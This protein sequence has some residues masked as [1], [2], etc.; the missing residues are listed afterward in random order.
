MK[1]QELSPPGI[2][3]VTG[4]LLFTAEEIIAFA[5]KFD[6]Q[7]FHT[8]A[9]AAKNYVFGGLVPPAGIPAPAG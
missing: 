1:L 7:P 6:P 8:D 2:R 5:T 3:V 9:E 4:S